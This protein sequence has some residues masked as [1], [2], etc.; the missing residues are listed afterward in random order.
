[1]LHD[2]AGNYVFVHFIGDGCER[3]WA[4]VVGLQTVSFLSMGPH[5]LWSNGDH[6]GC[7]PDCRDS[8]LF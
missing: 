8:S 6:I 2:I 7:G 4:V 3:Y 5:W 1:M